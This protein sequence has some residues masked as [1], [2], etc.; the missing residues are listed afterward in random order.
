MKTALFLLS[1]VAVAAGCCLAAAALVVPGGL[2]DWRV[3]AGVSFPVS[4]IWTLMAAYLIRKAWSASR[5]AKELGAQLMRREIELGRTSTVD[6]LT[7]LATRREFDAMVRLE[8]ARFQRHGH[9]TSLLMVELDDIGR[10]GETV[11]SL[12]KGLVIAE[13]ASIL[14]QSLRAIDLGCRFTETGLAILLLETPAE[15]ARIVTDRIREAVSHQTFLAHRRD[16]KHQLTVSQGVATLDV[17]MT[18]HLDFVRAAERALADARTAGFNQ[19]IIR[20]AA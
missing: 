14:K 12:T 5:T 6:E 9:P 18:S 4:V 13:L 3:V 2:E 1:T 11:G 15:Q 17:S 10:L 16:G 19:I 8:F 20:A 7:G